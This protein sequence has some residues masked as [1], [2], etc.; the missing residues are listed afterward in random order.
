MFTVAGADGRVV[1]CA[2][3]AS[4][5]AG[6][7]GIRGL[8]PRPVLLVHGTADRTLG[9]GCSERLYEMYGGG[10]GERRLVLLEGDDHCL[11]KGAERA[12][13]LLWAFVVKCAGG[14]V[15]GGE[16]VEGLVKGE[17]MGKEERR[18]GMRRGGDLRG[19]EGEE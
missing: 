17:L 2:T 9:W 11:S 15:G 18:E 7:E 3:V 4:Q 5:T 16:E 13:E 19:G 6:T 12:E 14:E 10:E 8:P 1:G